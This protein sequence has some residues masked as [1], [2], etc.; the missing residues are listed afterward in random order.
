MQLKFEI[1]ERGDGT[2]ALSI[3]TESPNIFATALPNYKLEPVSLYEDMKA[4]VAR[5][6]KVKN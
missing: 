2:F 6:K 1:S 3:C 4:G 5:I